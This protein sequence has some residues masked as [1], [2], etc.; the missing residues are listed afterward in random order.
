ML[1][2]AYLKIHD[3]LSLELEH[4]TNLLIDP[5]CFLELFIQLPRYV[6]ALEF[7]IDKA[8]AEPIKYNQRLNL[9][10]PWEHRLFELRKKSPATID[11]ALRT[12]DFSIMIE[13]F[14]VSLF[15]QQEIKTLFP[16]S[17][18]RLEEK[19]KEICGL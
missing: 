7:R 16:I 9:I 13:E 1:N 15:A 5:Q 2:A 10:R 6:S 4:Y 14:K 11:Q 8:F 18:K 3:E 17:E 12:N 19:F